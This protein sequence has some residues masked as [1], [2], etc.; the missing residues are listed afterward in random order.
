MELGL[1]EELL[2]EAKVYVS[3]NNAIQASEKLYKV[4]EECIK[5]LAKKEN[6]PEYK[7]FEREGRWWSRLLS[8]SARTLAQKLKE[9]RIE[10]SWARA[11]DL[12]IWGFHEK[13][14]EIKHIESD[15][16]HAEWLLNYTKNAL[17]K[18]K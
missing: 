4:V 14:L 13:A 16:S 1:L 17:N 10:E 12:H 7:E 3:K 11:F 15:V 6:L 9:D 8:R 18:D 5:L 2:E